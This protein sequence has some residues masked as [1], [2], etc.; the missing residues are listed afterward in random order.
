MDFKKF[1]SNKKRNTVFIILAV[2]L[3]LDI[4]LGLICRFIVSDL[5]DQLTAERWDEDGGAAQVSLFF[6]ED[7]M[8]TV[9]N[10]RKLEYTMEKKMQ[11]TGITADDDDEENS[12]GTDKK[13]SPK[14]VD[15]KPIGKED[16]AKSE[17]ETAEEEPVKIYN[18]AYSAQGICTLAFENKKA[19]NIDAIGV[20][21]DFFL[22]H[23]MELVSGGYFGGDD[24]MKD[25]IVIDEYLAWQLFGS[26]D[27]IGQCVTISGINHYIAGVVKCVG[28]RFNEAA[29]LSR[30]TVYMSYD[31]LA[32]YG[33]ILS[34]RISE[35]E[36]S[37]DGAKMQE[38]GISCYEVVMP[39]PVDGIALSIVKESAGL[40][41]KYI[42]VVDNTKRFGGFALFDVIRGFGIRSMWTQPIYYPYWENVARGWEDVLGVIFL[43]RIIFKVAFWLIIAVLVV[44]AYRNKTWTVRGVVK[45]LADRKYEF[46]ARR[47]LISKD[48]NE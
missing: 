45:D 36:I 26:S 9:D 42:A 32:K 21:G 44:I 23:P 8:I 11:E 47:K 29:G 4:I 1:F 20:G 24:L 3:L 7:Q 48:K 34:G 28:G 27:I 37:E 2:L 12:E 46:E 31:S 13:G 22:F 35:I 18:S 41:D 43:F 5:P 6:T 39:E 25:K 33:T 17:E 40:E 15:T 19:E 30:S 16:S 10:I 14:I 38:G